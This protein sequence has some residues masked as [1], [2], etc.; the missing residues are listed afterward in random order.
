MN[1]NR[2]LISIVCR[3]TETIQSYARLGKIFFEIDRTIKRLGAFAN[4]EI[5]IA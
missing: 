4:G 5:Q 3:V 1:K 2:S